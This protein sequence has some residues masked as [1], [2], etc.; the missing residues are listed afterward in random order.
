M[1]QRKPTLRDRKRLAVQEE[2]QA[3][4]VDLFVANGYESTTVDQIAAAAGLSPRSFFRYFAGKEAVVTHMLD[5]AGTDIAAALTARPSEEEPWYALRRS[6]DD[7]IEALTVGDQALAMMRLIY[8]TQ[9]LYASHLHQQA[10]WNEAIAE[11]LLPRLAE[12]PSGDEPRLRA[13]ALAAAGV[14]C[15]EYARREWVACDGKRPVARLLDV[16]MAAV[17]PLPGP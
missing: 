12:A 8:D 10:Q 14:A 3:V 17:A 11:A 5:K 1:E 2:V 7:V 9:V 6:F 13:G 16:A 4:A 15:F